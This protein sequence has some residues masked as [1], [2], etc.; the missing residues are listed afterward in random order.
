MA[1]A[2]A[3]HLSRGVTSSDFVGEADARA[4][5]RVASAVA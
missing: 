5:P 3:T 2:E 1:T 4:V